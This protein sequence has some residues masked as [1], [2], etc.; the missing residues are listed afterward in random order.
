MDEDEG[1]THPAQPDWSPADNPHAIA[2]SEA[3]WWQHAAELAALRLGDPDDQRIAWPSSRQIDA[4]QLVLALR[5][6]LSAARLADLAMEARGVG[7]PAR[8]ALAQAR[9]QFED[10]LPGVKNMRD[11]LI[12]FD[13]WSRG[14]GHGPQKDR[15]DAGHALRDV[16]REFWGFGYD[17][18]AGTVSLGP[19][20]IQV[21]TAAKAAKELSWAIY[22]AARAVDQAHAA[23]VLARTVAVLS[24][25]GISCSPSREA[26]VW[27]RVKEDSR[28]WLSLVA[29]P[30]DPEG[31]DLQEQIVHTLADAGLQL[32][33]IQQAEDLE[34]V[35][36]LARGEALF[37]E[38][39][40][41]TH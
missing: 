13:E 27:V 30:S 3:Q 15:R 4:R 6:L 33:S 35:E 24:A 38:A 10:A 41:P 17:P 20:T 19:Y 26:P 14:R 36:R 12:H 32:V 37:V 40:Q 11:A 5:Q 21:D 8:E 25:A 16:A 2:I 29:G 31:H 22:S 1:V 7:A 34:T 9:Q 39:G 18:N 28:V 23:D